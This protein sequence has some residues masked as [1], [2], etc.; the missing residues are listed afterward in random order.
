MKDADKNLIEHKRFPYNF[1]GIIIGISMFYYLTLIHYFNLTEQE[2]K[3]EE[4]AI[5]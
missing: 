3:M 4:I 2:L 5:G 1:Y